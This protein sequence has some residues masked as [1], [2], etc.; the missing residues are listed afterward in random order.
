MIPAHSSGASSASLNPAG[1]GWAKASATDH[2]LGVPAVE[3]PAGVDR[4]R[5]QVLLAPA[6]EH[7][8]AVGPA[9]ARRPRPGHR[10]RTGRCPARSPTT[11]ATTSW[12]GVVSGRW[13]AGRPRP[14]AGRCG[15]R[16]S[17]GSAAA[18]GR[19]RAGGPAARPGAAGPTRPAR[20]DELPMH[21]QSHRTGSP[22]ARGTDPGVP[23]DR[24]K[25][26]TTLTVDGPVSM[27]IWF[28][29]RPKSARS[30]TT[31]SARRVNAAGLTSASVPVKLSGRV[32]PRP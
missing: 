20:A 12:P 19:D 32:S 22:R 14:G 3:V 1:S 8:G 30:T 9:A 4:G 24:V 28:Q 7:A 6:A 5:A 29:V 15:T 21:A 27:P 23:Q 31:P 10:A 11:S 25:R 2:V 26:A 16:R 18:A 13:A 17:S